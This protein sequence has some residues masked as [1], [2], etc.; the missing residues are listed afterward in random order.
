MGQS[1]TDPSPPLNN[2]RSQSQT[3][4]WVSHIPV[5][6][7][8]VFVPPLCNAVRHQYVVYLLR[9]LLILQL[10][11]CAALDKNVKHVS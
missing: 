8:P 5:P 6:V 3:D 2:P 4:I 1:A 10:S 11:H 7:V 9:C